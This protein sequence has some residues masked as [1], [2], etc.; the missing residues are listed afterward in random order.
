MQQKRLF[1]EI[2]KEKVMSILSIAF[3][4]SV[5]IPA[6]ETFVATT[7]TMARPLLG[8]SAVAVLAVIFKPLLIGLLR[9]A[10]LVLKP[11]QSLEERE[12]RR[13]R[14]GVLMLNRMAR[15]LNDTQP[16]LA[17]ELRWLASRG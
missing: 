11:R 13:T 12:L 8:L 5:A 16:G 3:P 10:L 9:A 14:K 7:V 17:A 6:A 2:N 4:A 15:D 1:D